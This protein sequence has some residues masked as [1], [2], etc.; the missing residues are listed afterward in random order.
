MGAMKDFAMFCQRWELDPHQR[1]SGDH[2]QRGYVPVV[3]KIAEDRPLTWH[4]I[5]QMTGGG[6]GKFDMACPWCGAGQTHSARF[7]IKRPTLNAAEWHCFYCGQSGAA[8]SGLTVDPAEE[9]AAHKAAYT[10][11][12]KQKAGR[13]ARALLI[14]DAATTIR[15][16]LAETF[17]AA[18]KIKVMPPD[19]DGVLRW[20]PAL[21]G[22]G[23]ERLPAIIALFRDVLTDKPVAIHRTFIL[24]A[25]GGKA[26]RMSLGPRA[27]AAVKLWP[28]A[29]GEQLA[30]GEG[31]ETC[32]AAIQL[33]AAAPPIWA[34]TVANN[35]PTVPVIEG[36]KQLTILADNDTEDGAPG[37]GEVKARALRIN[38]LA[39]GRAV[40]LFMPP[41]P[42][43]DFNTLLGFGVSHE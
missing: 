27:G 19:V 26:V 3:A 32:L 2:Y 37:V 14:W 29:G 21:S 31:I 8:K 15:G 10:L 43:Q 18:R 40:R 30:I 34:A 4:E 17:F 16:T 6:I 24:D 22:Y 39:A 1:S 5:D 25:R 12:Q 36:V 7:Q 28:L 13:I 20:H 42:K 11:E 41:Q 33:G 9:A 38:W 35:M 23:R